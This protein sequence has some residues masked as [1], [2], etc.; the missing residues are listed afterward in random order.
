VRVLGITGGIGTGKSTVA[1]MFASCGA[2]VI[3]ADRIAHSL[4]VPGTVVYRGL[5]RLFG[6]AILAQDGAVDRR[7]L[8]A[9]VF[10]DPALRRKV[11]ALMHPV[12]REKIRAQIREC[13]GEVVVLDAPLLFEAG[14]RSLTD[15]VVVVTASRAAQVHRCSVGRAMSARELTRRRAAQMPLAR[16]VRMADF[17]IDN[18]GT[19]AATRQQAKMIWETISRRPAR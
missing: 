19:R 7:A 5:L 15:K 14:C 10:S 9:R 18:G 1:Q 6:R 8:A 3:D 12:I 4:L 16:K 11:E 2:R 17:V 13:R